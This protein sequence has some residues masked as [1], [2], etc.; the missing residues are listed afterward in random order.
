QSYLLGTIAS[1]LGYLLTKGGLRFFRYIM[2]DPQG[3]PRLTIVVNNTLYVIS[4]LVIFLT[5]MFATLNSLRKANLR[6]T[7]ELLKE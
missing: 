3:N 2:R 1:I 6:S 7:T 5:I 4:F